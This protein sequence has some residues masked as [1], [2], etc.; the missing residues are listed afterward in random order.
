VP[1]DVLPLTGSS[2]EINEVNDSI[3]L[4]FSHADGSSW[5]RHVPTRLFAAALEGF[6]AKRK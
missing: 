6:L 1:H 4:A 3:E 2:F 5:I